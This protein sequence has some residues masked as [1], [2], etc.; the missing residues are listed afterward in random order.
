MRQFF[1]WNSQP[2]FRY[3]TLARST[4]CLRISLWCQLLKAKLLA[5][6]LTQFEKLNF[7]GRVNVPSC[8][9]ISSATFFAFL[10][11]DPQCSPMFLG[12]VFSLF[13]SAIQ[14]FSVSLLKDNIRCNLNGRNNCSGKAFRMTFFFTFT[15]NSYF[16]TPLF[17]LVERN[18]YRLQSVEVLLKL[19]RFTLNT[20]S[21]N[22][23]F[24]K[25]Y[26]W[27]RFASLQ[28]FTSGTCSE[29]NCST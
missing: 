4:I 2:L 9:L 20:L 5:N 25:G 8:I 19:I 6:N 7:T 14:G 22:E 28:A 12:W 11:I 1:A 13:T 16:S 24:I 27:R 17:R 29:S 26:V 23:S 21:L 18:L 15:N 10:V 3:R